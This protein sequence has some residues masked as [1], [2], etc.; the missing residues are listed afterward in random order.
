VK[1]LYFQGMTIDT[2]HMVL[3][4][5]VGAILVGLPAYGTALFRRRRL[6]QQF[7]DK[8]GEY[9]ELLERYNPYYKSLGVAGRERFLHRALCFME[10]K[11][12]EYIDVAPQEIMPLL[13]SATA[14][15]LTFGLEHY[16]LDHFRTIHILQDR[17]RYGLYN[18]PF[19]GHV[20]EDGI[21]FSWNHFFREYADYSDGQNVGLHEMAHALTYVNFSVQDGRDTTFHDHFSEFSSV[22]RPLFERM[23]AGETLLL[24]P[25]AATNYQEFWAVCVETFFERSNSMKKQLPELY[26]ALCILLNQDPLTA[27][28]LLVVDTGA[29]PLAPTTPPATAAPTAPA[30]AA[31]IAPQLA[32]PQS[33]L[34]VAGR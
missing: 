32:P 27:D 34:G 33:D 19:E 11:K 13:I 16:L 12:F 2:V 17:Y 22:A 21:Y 20:A 28:K 25:Y 4:L 23:Q 10:V 18:Q 5:L 1:N 26:S 15:Q 29:L 31:A 3:Y 7:A 9:D 6:R 14:V 30:T 24:D 8:H